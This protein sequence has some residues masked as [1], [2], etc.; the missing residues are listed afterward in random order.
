MADNR[1]TPAMSDLPAP[2]P[3]ALPATHPAASYAPPHW[4]RR[5][6][7]PTSCADDVSLA[8]DELGA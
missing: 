8:P 1:Q 3:P 6:C 4:R 2:A 7:V 5:R